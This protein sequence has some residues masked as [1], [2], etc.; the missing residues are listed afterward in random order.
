MM[1]IQAALGLGGHEVCG[2]KSV[3]GAG[4]GTVPLDRTF[5][6]TSGA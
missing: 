3:T 6:N 4:R 1:D 5:G 2:V